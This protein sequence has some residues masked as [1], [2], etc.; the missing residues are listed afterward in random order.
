MLEALNTIYYFVLHF[1][2]IFIMATEYILNS[3]YHLIFIFNARYKISGKRRL[4]KTRRLGLL[5]DWVFGGSAVW[6]YMLI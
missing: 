6:N 5:W 4:L 2:S 1:E 3:K